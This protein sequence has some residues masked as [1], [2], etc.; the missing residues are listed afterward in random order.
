[1]S[2]RRDSSYATVSKRSFFKTGLAAAGPFV[3]ASRKAEA[4]DEAGVVQGGREPPKLEGYDQPDKRECGRDA[5]NQFL[6]RKYA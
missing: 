4:K 3:I 6:I 2:T 1:M 5:A